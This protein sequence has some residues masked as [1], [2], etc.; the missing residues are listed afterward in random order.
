MERE[1][2][3]AEKKHLARLESIEDPEERK[4]VDDEFQAKKEKEKKDYDDFMEEQERK[5]LEKDS[6]N[7]RNNQSPPGD[8]DVKQAIKA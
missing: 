8:K 3:K 6:K 2:K 1:R 4:R 7:L 5:K